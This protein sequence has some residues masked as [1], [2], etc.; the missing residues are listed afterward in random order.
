MRKAI[1]TLASVLVLSGLCAADSFN[2]TDTTSGV[3]GTQYQLDTAPSGCLTSC[4]ATFTITTNG[5][6]GAYIGWIGFHLDSGNAASI[7]SLSLSGWSVATG[8]GVNVPWGSNGATTYAL[9][10]TG[11]WSA[12]YANG[13]PGGDVTSGLALNGG[14]Y[15]MTFDFAWTGAGSLNSLPSLQVGYYVLDSKGGYKT[16]QMSQVAPEPA[17]A[18]FVLLSLV[19]LAAFRR[20]RLRDPKS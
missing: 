19:A 16:T 2:W 17:T 20:R 10:G 4:S 1:L 14:P 18:S 7:T 13:L 6:S 9:P 15:S 5:L 12:I 11:G 8:T 3:P